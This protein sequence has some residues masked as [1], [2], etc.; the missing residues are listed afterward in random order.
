MKIFIYL[1]P[2]FS[3]LAAIFLLSACAHTDLSTSKSI[4]ESEVVQIEPLISAEWLYEN[5]DNPN[6][7][8]L[9]ATVLVEVDEQGEMQ[10]LSGRPNYNNSHI[11][12]AIFADLMGD[13]SEQDSELT[14]VLP[15]PEQFA[16]AMGRLGVGNDSTVVIYSA[17]F[18]S[19]SA[20]V[21]WMLKW[22]GFDNAALLNGG[23]NA[24]TSAGYPTSAE[25]VEPQAKQLSINLRPELVADRNEVFSSIGNQSVTIVD[26]LP[27]ASYNGEMQMYARA[28]HIPGAINVPDFNHLD[29]DGKYRP[30]DEL[31]MLYDADRRNRAITYCGGGVSASSVA[32]NMH[33]LGF[34]N[35]AV[36]MGSLQEWAPDPDNP[37]LIGSE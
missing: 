2:Y 25:K 24:W 13:L 37:M 18:P 10:T 1:K 33:R 20:R 31:D 28:G 9:D 3:L 26:S 32:F 14:F 12:G 35:V 30:V 27:E 4:Q 5:L 8:I 16:T 34:E 23:F 22:I 19:W 36:Y 7:V 6:L 15:S 11:P 17:S 29:E 21:W